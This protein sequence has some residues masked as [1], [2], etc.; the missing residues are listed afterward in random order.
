MSFDTSDDWV[1]EDDAR[2][3][4]FI[5]PQQSPTINFHKSPFRF[6]DWIAGSSSSPPTS[7]QYK[8]FS[9]PVTAGNKLFLRARV[10][11]ADHRLSHYLH[12]YCVIIP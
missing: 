10:S 9:T 7:P 3:H 11:R 1:N 5:S 2:A 12:G 8:F 4:I 6:W